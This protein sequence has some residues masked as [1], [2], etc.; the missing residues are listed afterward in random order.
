MEQFL[1]KA[2]LPEFEVIIKSAK[3]ATVEV[4]DGDVGD[5]IDALEAHGF[6]YDLED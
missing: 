2:E 6:N 4:P 3:Q 1:K 5:L